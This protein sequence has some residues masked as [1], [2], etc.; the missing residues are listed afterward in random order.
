MTVAL[1]DLTG[2]VVVVT[3]AGSG[4]GA[5]TARQLLEA[6]ASV[7]ATDLDADRIAPLVDAFG[8]RVVAV[9]ADAGLPESA[10][11]VLEAAVKTFGRVDSV[12][13]NAGVGF[14]GGV[15]D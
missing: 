10:V 4:I 3:G 8:D 11:A 9:G 5:A 2:T 12:V 6:G 14:F 1:R 15:L 13:A 7:V